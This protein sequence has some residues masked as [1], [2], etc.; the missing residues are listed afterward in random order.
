MKIIHSNLQGWKSYGNAHN[1]E[2]ITFQY[3]YVI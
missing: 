1:Y 3:E 2:I